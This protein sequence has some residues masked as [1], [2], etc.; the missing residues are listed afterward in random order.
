MHM[1]VTSN[2]RTLKCVL[3]RF[4]LELILD[5]ITLILESMCIGF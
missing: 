3:I 1:D 5:P 2:T 4:L